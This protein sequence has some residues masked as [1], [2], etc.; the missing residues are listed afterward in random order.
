MRETIRGAPAGAVLALVIGM[1]LVAAGAGIVLSNLVEW[2]V[3]VPDDAIT[4][5][6]VSVNTLNIGG[7]VEH[8]DLPAD[9]V[10]SVVY[11]MGLEMVGHGTAGSVAISVI[12]YKLDITDTDLTMRFYD[13]VGAAWTN[14]TLSES[15][16]T[17]VGVFSPVGGW[18]VDSSFDVTVPLLLSFSMSGT[19]DFDAQ[20]VP[21]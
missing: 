5:S 19:Y 2:Q 14:I 3:V 7:E 12:V 15:G 13:D 11:D 10:K 16:D 8:T 17:L 20:V 6:K 1:A 4:L 18:S 21:Y 9:P